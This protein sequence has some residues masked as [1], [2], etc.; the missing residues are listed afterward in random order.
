MH[1][2]APLLLAKAK[3]DPDRQVSEITKPQALNRLQYRGKMGQSQM[4]WGEMPQCAQGSSAVGD[5]TAGTKYRFSDSLWIS[6]G[7]IVTPALG[8]QVG[9]F[10]LSKSHKLRYY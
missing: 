9:R 4:E 10:R 8:E 7:L 1:E 2:E 3:V 6:L 5:R